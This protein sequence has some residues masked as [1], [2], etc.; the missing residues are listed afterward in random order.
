[1][2]LRC[3][4]Q[5]IYK[6]ARGTQRNTPHIPRVALNVNVEFV[7]RS[8]GISSGLA[9][10]IRTVYFASHVDKSVC[11]GLVKLRCEATICVSHR[12]FIYTRWSDV[13]SIC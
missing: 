12:T 10:S 11:Y 7:L 4:K 13:S 5:S 9:K 3:I 8:N 2:Q 6:I 1:M